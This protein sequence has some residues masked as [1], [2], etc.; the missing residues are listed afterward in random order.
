MANAEIERLCDYC[1]AFAKESLKSR[2]ELPPF[3]VIRRGGALVPV[4][5]KTDERTP[6]SGPEAAQALTTGL[7]RLATE[8]QATVLAL[9]WDEFVSIEGAPGTKT[10]AIVIGLE[11]ENGEAADVFVPYR[12]RRLL[13]YSFGEM[14]AIER[15]RN[16]FSSD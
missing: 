8:Q 6:I 4:F 7:R 1:L 11:H 2:G 3:A 15:V 10:D 13:G 14:I 5:P 16:F 9:C 12:K